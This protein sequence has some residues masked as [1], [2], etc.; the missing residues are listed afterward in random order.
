MALTNYDRVGKGLDLLRTGLAPFVER[1]LKNLYRARALTEALNFVSDDR[2]LVGQPLAQWDVSAL[3]KLMWNAWKD[4]FRQPLGNAE[5]SLVS[6]LRDFR[7]RWAHQQPFST[8]DAYRV[9]DS[10]GRLL[11]AVSAS[12]ADEVEKIKLELLRVR[13]DEQAR[14]EKRKS[15]GTAIES[16]VAG[17]LKPW[18]E[19]VNPHRDV[20]SGRYQ[21][22]EFAADLWQVRL[23][24]GSDEYRKPVE[25][26][27]RT[28]LTESLKQLLIGAVRRLTGTGGDPV[29]QLQTNF[30]GG[31][32]HSMLVLYHLFSGTTPRELLGVE[33]I[34]HEA[35]ETPQGH[36]VFEFNPDESQRLSWLGC[37]PAACRRDIRMARPPQQPNRGV[38]KRCH[39]LGDT[40]TAHL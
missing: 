8:D 4:V 20:A 5:R 36:S 2:N 33:E 9:L 37:Q 30:G 35:G 13:F 14:H 34:L 22:A 21:Q 15:A 39:D 17:G 40:A 31:K 10:A 28:F 19:V 27:R 32:T 6:E 7:N 23:N 11:A 18:R 12:Q 29:V 1:E 16:Q 38:A 25:F 24:E 26:Y 3:L